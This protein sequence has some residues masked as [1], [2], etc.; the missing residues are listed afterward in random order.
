MYATLI[1]SLLNHTIKIDFESLERVWVAVY[2]TWVWVVV[3]RTWAQMLMWHL[4]DRLEVCRLSCRSHLWTSCSLSN[5][6][7]VPP[8]WSSELASVAWKLDLFRSDQLN[9]I[10][11]FSSS[12]H[13]NQL[14]LKSHQRLYWPTTYPCFRSPKR[15][16]NG[17]NLFRSS[18]SFESILSTLAT[19]NIEL[20]K[21]N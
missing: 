18:K 6:T 2:S 9:H 21:Y 11:A 5:L 15:A 20:I 16:S 8:I 10:Y 19:Y 13:P 12:N 17:L 4:S 1:Q 3:Y 14:D 7:N